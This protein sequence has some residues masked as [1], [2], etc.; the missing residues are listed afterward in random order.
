MLKNFFKGFFGTIF[1]I[2][3]SVFLLIGFAFI[4]AYYLLTEKP[5]DMEMRIKERNFGL[6]R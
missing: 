4:G 6:N 1:F 3:G 2:I 5:S